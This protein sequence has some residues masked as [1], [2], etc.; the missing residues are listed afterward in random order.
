M[1]KATA[2]TSNN[3]FG[4]NLLMKKEHQK[5]AQCTALK[6][7]HNSKCMIDKQVTL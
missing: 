1:F 5:M 7:T 3:T 2:M 6:L 4:F